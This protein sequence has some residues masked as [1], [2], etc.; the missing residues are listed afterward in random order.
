MAENFKL[1]E[2]ITRE[3]NSDSWLDAKKRMVS[4]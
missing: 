2:A 3:S 4:I 1:F